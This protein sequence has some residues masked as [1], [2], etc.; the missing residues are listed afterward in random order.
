MNETPLYTSRRTVRSLWQEYRVYRDRL[1][2]QSWIFLHTIVVPKDEIQ[3]VEVRP[4]FFCGGCKGLTLGIKIDNCDLC[5]HVL[6]TKKQGLLKGIAFSPDE[7][8]KFVE[9][10]KSILPGR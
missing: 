9:V 5:R 8:E 7:P 1:E 4:S 3:M 2:L 6:V 10:C